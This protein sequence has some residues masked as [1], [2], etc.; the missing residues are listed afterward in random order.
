M[1]TW[2]GDR[3]FVLLCFFVGL[4]HLLHLLALSLQIS[5]LILLDLFHAQV[6]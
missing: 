2:I 1:G 3:Y 4:F 6:P 5:F